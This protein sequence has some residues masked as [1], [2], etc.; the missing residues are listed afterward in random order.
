[1][2]K[3]RNEVDTELWLIAN[4]CVVDLVSDDLTYIVSDYMVSH[5]CNNII[6]QAQNELDDEIN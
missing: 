2:I 6:N 1:M 5:I 3:V 4:K